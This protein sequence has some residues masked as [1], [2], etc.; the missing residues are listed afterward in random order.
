MRAADSIPDSLGGLFGWRFHRIGPN[1]LKGL[2]VVF[3]RNIVNRSLQRCLQLLV[4]FGHLQQL[5]FVWSLWTLQA[6]AT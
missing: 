3:E 4:T 2:G 1:E 5:P 6:N